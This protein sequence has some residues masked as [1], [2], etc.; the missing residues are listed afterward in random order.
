MRLTM[1]G[2]QHTHF[3]PEALETTKKLFIEALTKANGYVSVACK[4]VNIDYSTFVDWKEKDEEFYKE[5]EKI[6]VA[7]VDQYMYYLDA[8]A[9]EKN[10]TAIIYYLNRK[11]Y[12]CGLV[13][14]GGRNRLKN[15]MKRFETPAQLVEGIQWIID[16]AQ[17]G[18]ITHDDAMLYAGLLE[19]KRKTFESSVLA[20]KVAELE[21]QLNGGMKQLTDVSSS[22]K[23]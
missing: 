16:E 1:A 23:T 18:R 12:Y 15:K 13:N 21:A 9:K 22:T 4:A 10:V 7:R 8:A 3:T 2:G 17:H 20:V 5:V 11:G 14:K 19:N 6:E